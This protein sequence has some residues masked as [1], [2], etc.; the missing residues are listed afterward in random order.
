MH[1]KQADLE[2]RLHTVFTILDEKLE[3]SY[4]NLFR[5]H[6]NRLQ[7]GKAASNAYDG[8]FSTGPLF[9]LGYGTESGKGYII[10]IDIS[11]LERVP[12]KVRDEIE[13]FAV[14]TLNELLKTHF[15]ERELS[16][17]KEK[18][19]YKI[20]GDFSLGVV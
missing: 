1:P 15:P 10:D 17:I 2:K 8:L 11:T 18:N 6:P 14:Q 19:I 16:I 9:T 13:A 4:G 20:V 5:L 12:S 3:D 7:R